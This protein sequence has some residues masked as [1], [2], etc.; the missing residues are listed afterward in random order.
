MPI[1]NV[2]RRGRAGICHFWGSALLYVPP[3]PGTPLETSVSRAHT[4]TM[5]PHDPALPKIAQLVADAQ[6]ELK[7]IGIDTEGKRPDQILNMA[8]EA[9]NNP[10][11]ARPIE[12][13]KPK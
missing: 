1:L 5:T 11:A 2:F 10:C 12:Q 8:R 7:R 4:R 6:K 13:S 9:R 3:E